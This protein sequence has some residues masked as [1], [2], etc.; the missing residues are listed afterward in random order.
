LES[1]LKDESLTWW[2]TY[3]KTNPYDFLLWLNYGDPGDL[4]S[5]AGAMELFLQRKGVRANPTHR[6][7]DLFELLQA[8]QPNW[9]GLD[10]RYLAQSVLP[11]AGDLQGEQLKDWLSERLRS[12]FRYCKKPP[13]WIQSPAWPIGDNG[14]LVF[15]GQIN[16]KNCELFHDEAA[17]YVFIDPQS[18]QTQTVIQVY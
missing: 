9:L 10:T 5:A 3:I 4:L 17:V 2:D 1:F 16:L 11:D 6:Y 12:L 14:P 15:L 13:S 18:G 8:A 7:A